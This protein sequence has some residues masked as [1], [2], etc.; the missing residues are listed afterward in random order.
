M[1]HLKDTEDS[2]ATLGID[3][4]FCM[5][6]LVQ[7]FRIHILWVARNGSS[8]HRTPPQQIYCCHLEPSCA[9]EKQNSKTPPQQPERE[10]AAAS[11]PQRQRFARWKVCGSLR[12]AKQK[13]GVA[14]HKKH[15]STTAK[16]RRRQATAAKNTPQLR[17]QP[18]LGFRNTHHQGRVLFLWFPGS[19]YP[20]CSQAPAHCGRA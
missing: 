20:S 14:K 11:K 16:H 17:K 19:Y 13:R 12:I 9:A 10:Q 15:P 8:S 2:R 1:N 18:H 5:M 7:P 3:M 6:I 4:L